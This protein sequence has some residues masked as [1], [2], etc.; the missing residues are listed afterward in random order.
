MGYRDKTQR[1]AES[2]IVPFGKYKG[3]PAK[4]VPGDYWEYVSRDG[5]L[6]ENFPDLAAYVKSAKE[7]GT[8][9]G[10][11]DEDTLMPFGEYKG[12]KLERVPP[13]YLLWLA[14]QEWAEK[15]VPH[16]VEYVEEHRQELVF[17]LNEDERDDELY[18]D[19][20]IPF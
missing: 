3:Q 19:D 6:A 12:V 5:W 17:D 1:S 9:H 18:L 8:L 14:K 15:K 7:A 10:V 16:I 2:L 11:A 4:S 13:G 20:D